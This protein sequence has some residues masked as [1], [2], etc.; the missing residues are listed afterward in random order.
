[1]AAAAR[2]FLEVPPA[3]RRDSGNLA[4]GNPDPSLL[5]ELRAAFRSLQTAP[6]LYSD[7]LNF[8][9]LTDL[10]QRQFAADHVHTSGVAVVGGA[11]D[12]IER[13]LRES[14]P[15]RPRGR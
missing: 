4:D 7:E 11:L 15:R 6:R 5:A 8:S 1:M 12:G 3:F 2:G 10:A 14:P 9:P 13:V